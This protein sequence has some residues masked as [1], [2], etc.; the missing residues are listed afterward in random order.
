MA[1]TSRRSPTF[2]FLAVSMENNGPPADPFDVEDDEVEVEEVEEEVEV[3]EVEVEEVEV[4]EV[5]VE[6]EVE[7]ADASRFLALLDEPSP[8]DAPP[9]VVLRFFLASPPWEEE[10]EEEEEVLRRP[11]EESAR[12]RMFVLSISMV[13]PA[14]GRVSW[15]G[16]NTSNLCSTGTC[17][18]WLTTGSVNAP[19][20]EGRSARNDIVQRRQ[21]Q[22][23]RHE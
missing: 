20:D 21:P 2:I 18:F 4:D 13:C 22:Q 9:S 16:I 6:V 11:M 15:P 1:H 17:A 8:A 7:D 10:E 23:S 5:E 14:G 12:M 19:S 3:D